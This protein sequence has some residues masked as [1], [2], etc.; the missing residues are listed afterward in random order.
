VIEMGFFSSLWEG[1]K[2][3]AKTAVAVTVGLPIVAPI[4]IA[5]KLGL[6]DLDGKKDSKTTQEIT[7]ARKE[8]SQTSSLKKAT[9]VQ[10]VE[11]ISK[12][13]SNYRRI[14]ERNAEYAEQSLTDTVNNCFADLMRR[15]R[16]NEQI[17]QS[18]GF[19]KI[20]EE[21]N[22]LIS[23]IN[24]T[25]TLAISTKLSLDNYDC[26]RILDMEAGSDKDKKMKNFA[27][28]VINDAKNNLADKISWTMR[29]V[30]ND[31]SRFLE[32]KI[33]EKERTSQEE[34][35]K[36][37]NW[38]QKIENKTFD[39]ERAQLEPRIKIYAIEQVEKILAA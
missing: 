16:E 3:V 21:K 20:Q 8:V 11:D 17:S 33:N 4:V 39:S 35:R 30:S 38:I 12:S 23:Q 22:Q 18:F 9:T 2:D 31:I 37:D 10:Q 34:Q 14:Y 29:Q 13:L 7:Q 28:K 24:G 25:V 5:E 19:D 36:F 1:V 32:S 6:I 27:D 15:M 26:R